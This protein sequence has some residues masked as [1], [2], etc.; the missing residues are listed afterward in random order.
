MLRKPAV[1][2]AFYPGNKEQ[3][4]GMLEELFSKALN[5]D[6]DGELKAIVAPHA[7][8][9]FSG[10]VAATAYNVVKKH[11]KDFKDI[12][13]LGPS[14]YVALDGFA[15][16]ESDE[17]ETPLG[18]VKVG[19][20]DN[21]FQYEISHSKEHSIEVQ[22][23]FL[24]HTLDGLKGRTLYP[25]VVGDAEPEELAEVIEGEME[26][27]LIIASSDLSH[28]YPYDIAKRIDGNANECIPKLD[29]RCV[30]ERV[31]ACGKIGILSVMLLAKRLR[32]KA[33]LLQYMNSGDVWY[34]KNNVVGYGAYAFYL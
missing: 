32:W 22:I 11:A 28:Y 21:I 6:I 16:P 26:N 15:A 8:Y 13:I 34:D 24:Q 12:V 1:A 25:I 17:W 23:P 31:E 18:K 10:I 5:E 29:V 33:K 3:L 9:Q 7:G 14:H 20:L 19:R 4:E 2:G 27:K 30:W